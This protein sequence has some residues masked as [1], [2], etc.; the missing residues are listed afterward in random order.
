[1]RDN[2]RG[3]RA[4]QEVKTLALLVGCVRRSAGSFGWRGGGIQTTTYALVFSL[5]SL[6][7]PAEPETRHLRGGC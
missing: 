7:V 5:P 1:M 6:Y 2:K 4:D 3:E